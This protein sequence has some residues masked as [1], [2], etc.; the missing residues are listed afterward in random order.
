MS[1]DDELK[2][3]SDCMYSPILTLKQLHNLFTSTIQMRTVYPAQSISRK[4]Y[5]PLILITDNV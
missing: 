5:L 2:Q 4:Y 3:E 1:D